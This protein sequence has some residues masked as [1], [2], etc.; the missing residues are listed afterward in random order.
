MCVINSTCLWNKN[1][2]D[3]QCWSLYTIKTT[4]RNINPK[5]IELIL[6]AT[7]KDIYLHSALKYLNQ[8]SFTYLQHWAWGGC[9]IVP[10]VNFPQTACLTFFSTVTSLLP[11]APEDGFVFLF[12]VPSTASCR[13]SRNFFFNMDFV[14]DFKHTSI[15][16]TII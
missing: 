2:M 6:R 15:F 1:C 14:P 13:Q 3:N 10:A 4:E 8:N 12:L 9:G 11:G 5:F 16:S 7:I